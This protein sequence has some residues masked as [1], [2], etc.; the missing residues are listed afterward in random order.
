MTPD[1][2]ADA[3]SA[4]DATRRA[5]IGSARRMLRMIYWIMQ[6]E[7]DPEARLALH[8][9]AV[10]IRRT[11]IDLVTTPCPFAKPI[12][13]PVNEPFTPRVIGRLVPRRVA[14]SPIQRGAP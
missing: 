6:A 9:Q 14:T 10:D 13:A 3:K 4:R 1:Q 7:S 11:L 2:R 8:R 12:S 5:V